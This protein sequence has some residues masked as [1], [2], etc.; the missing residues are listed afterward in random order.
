M[1][2]KDYGTDPRPSPRKSSEELP[3]VM[4]PIMYGFSLRYLL[5]RR[6]WPKPPGR[7]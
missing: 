7:S 3:N 2:T 6:W 5:P 1:M 4:L